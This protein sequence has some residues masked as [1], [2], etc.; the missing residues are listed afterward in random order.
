ML[1]GLIFGMMIGG[2]VGVFVMGLLQVAREADES[3]H[4]LNSLDTDEIELD[5]EAED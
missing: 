3:I 4:E 5:Y 1:L 2:A